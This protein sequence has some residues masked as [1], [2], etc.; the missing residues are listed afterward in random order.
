MNGGATHVSN[1][2]TTGSSSPAASVTAARHPSIPCRVRR[3]RPELPALRGRPAR[4]VRSGRWV[5][6]GPP[7]GAGPAGPTGVT[8]ATG[9]AGA[10]G[11]TGDSGALLIDP[12]NNPNLVGDVTQLARTRG[13]TSVTETTRSAWV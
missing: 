8:G 10:T 13:P 7:G 6:R 9:I 3:D 5:R 4:S 12:R 11:A 1:V 2:A